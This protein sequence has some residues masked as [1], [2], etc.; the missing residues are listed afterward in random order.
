MRRVLLLLCL[1][2]AACSD[3][4]ATSPTT[5]SGAAPGTSALSHGTALPF[6]GSFA[7][8]TRGSTDCPPTCPPTTL[9]VR[10]TV[11]GTASHLGR[12][13]AVM[14]N[15]VALATGSATG[16]FTLTSADGDRLLA[17]TVGH[18]ESFQPP[19]LST[20]VGTATITGGTGRF[21]GASGTFHYRHTGAIDF[22]RGTATGSGSFAGT[23]DLNR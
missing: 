21:D 10:G 2:A 7:I 12:F 8:D 13:T 1:S 9:Y 19:N 5:P 22:V 14:E 17:T 4:A 6:E 23:L 11:E 20:V 3:G 18:E 15:V 16:T